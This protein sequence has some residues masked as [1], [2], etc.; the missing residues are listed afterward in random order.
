MDYFSRKKSSSGKYYYI[1]KITGET[2]WGF[3]TYFKTNK[4]LPKGWI[5]LNFNGKPVYKYIRTEKVLTSSYSY[6]PRELE[7]I[8]K[9]TYQDLLDQEEQEEAFRRYNLFE[10]VARFL[11]LTTE[12]ICDESLQYLAKKA[13]VAPEEII[14]YIQ[15]T[16]RK[17]LGKNSELT[18][19]ST[20]ILSDDSFLTER[21]IRELCGVNMR[22]EEASKVLSQ[23][24]EQLSCHIS[25]EI[26]KDPV[27][28]S[29]GH[30]FDRDAITIWLQTNKTCPI[31]RTSITNYIVPNHA[32][33]KV[34]EKFA[35]KYK[36]QK[37]DIWKSI[38]KLCLDYENFTGRLTVPEYV[39]VPESETEEETDSDESDIAG[40]EEDPDGPF[41]EGRPVDSPVGSESR[42]SVSDI[43]QIGRTAEQIRDY[44][45]DQEYNI[46]YIQDIPEVISQSE[47]SSYRQALREATRRYN[48]LQER[49][50]QENSDSDSDESDFDEM[51]EMDQIGRTAEEIRQFMIE[52]EYGSDY[53][54][55]IPE[56]IAQYE[57]SSYHQAIREAVRRYDD[58]RRRIPERELRNERRAREIAIPEMEMPGRTA[59]QIREYM[60][61]ERFSIREIDDIP[62][63]IARSRES[64]YHRAA[65]EVAR[66][67]QTAREVSRRRR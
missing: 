30:T 4:K 48:A 67:R 32:L 37:G 40:E 39:Q 46:E 58:L 51:A 35:E 16:E 24:D 55:V 47:E 22:E 8:L 19:F 36:N 59:E 6:A 20:I 28:C 57:E 44:M 27:T 1:N 38:V 31:T 34:L 62:E 41:W 13:N 43:D 29:S 25:R 12:S 11:K 21:S 10:K 33:R 52:H 3:N 56:I 42:D 45:I 60:R 49:R 18:A 7:E 65:R 64:S 15:E 17:Q 61:R 9:M 23:I 26:F 63:V 5:R 14:A 54:K 50:I 66:R 53:I 2:Q